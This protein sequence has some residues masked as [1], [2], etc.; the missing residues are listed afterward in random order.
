MGDISKIKINE[1]AALNIK[2]ATGRANMTTLLGG[3]DLAALGSA[4]W[5]NVVDEVTDGNLNPVTSNAVADAIAALGH[6]LHFVGIVTKQEGETE[7]EAVERIYPA[8]SQ[9]AGA[10]VI[11]G[12]K[13]FICA[14]DPKT[15][16]ELGDESI[17]ET[18]AHAAA[19]FVAK[20]LTIAGIDLQDNITA[21]ELKTALGLG[22]MAYAD[23]A[24][25]SLSTVDSGSVVAG[26]AG[27]YNVSAQTVSVPK[28]YAALD[29]TPAGAVT[30]TKK[31]AG[32]VEYQK[33]TSATLSGAAASEGQTANYTPAGTVSAPH[34]TAS[35][36]LKETEVATVTDAGTAYEL[37][38]GD[39]T[40]AADTTS[41]FA[42]TGM[43][44][45]LDAGDAECL[46]FTDAQTANAVTASG[47]I[48]Y[49]KQAFTAGALPTF[50]TKNVVIKTGSTASAALDNAPVFSGTGAVLSAELNY[51]PTA[52]TLV[53]AE[54]EAGFSG[55]EK[56]VTPTVA[57][58]ENA[59]VS[60][61]KVTVGSD[62]FAVD[63]VRTAKTV[64]VDP[65]AK[66]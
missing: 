48:T 21:A 9:T 17:Y 59:S 47:A 53:D 43:L 63:F 24:S 61:G 34:I 60:Q 3:H 55:T 65:I 38:D 25:G 29:V 57:T 58:T 2:D 32:S 19:T 27:E 22:A 35:V 18:S 30:V 28:T 50:S 41:T 11:C 36:D 45:A 26:K 20:T 23:Q 16:H 66:V 8:V 13:E 7:A 14:G 49:T 31:T 10:V 37:S 12:N 56:S 1:G 54:Y 64:T 6:A 5:L 42:K 4:A 15:W 44:A 52:G 62:T 40:Q 33:A 39:V 46:V 51:T